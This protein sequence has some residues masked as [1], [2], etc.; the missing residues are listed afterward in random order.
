M[1]SRLWKGGP[2]FVGLLLLDSG[3]EVRG[4]SR[5]HNIGVCSFSKED[6]LPRRASSA[7]VAYYTHP[8]SLF[9]YSGLCV[10]KFVKID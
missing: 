1:L 7:Y 6:V 10:P 9:H 8:I 4:G 3:G 5:V 2:L